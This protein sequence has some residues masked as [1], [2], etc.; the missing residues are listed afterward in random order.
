MNPDRSLVWGVFLVL[1]FVLALVA[2]C[3]ARDIRDERLCQQAGYA[4]LGHLDSAFLRE[5]RVC[6]GVRDGAYT[7]T[8]LDSARERLER[9][10]EEDVR[11]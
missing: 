9:K 4:G 1:V 3:A 11:K 10:M 6:V 5:K 7:I 2:S 8:T